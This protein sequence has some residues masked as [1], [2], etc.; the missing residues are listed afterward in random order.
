MTHFRIVPIF[1]LGAL[2]AGA[3]AAASAPAAA[4]SCVHRPV[5]VQLEGDSISVGTGASEV[6]ATPPVLLRDAVPDA[7]VIATGIVGTTSAD[8]ILGRGGYQPFP[9]GVVGDVYVTQFGVNNAWYGMSVARFKADVRRL[10]TIPGA[11]LVTPTPIDMARAAP[12]PETVDTERYARA[13]RAVAAE[14]GAPL[15]DVHAYVLSL[16]DWRTFLVDG[17]H[18]GDVLY[19]RIY[20]EVVGPVVARLSKAIA[21]RPSG[22]AGAS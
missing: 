17:V 9:S 11:V 12:R 1:C 6:A 10:A 19:R 15:A 16:P 13:V 3:G 22:G 18:P 5:V 7:K 2:A 8:R 14:T 20:A 21:C 4:T